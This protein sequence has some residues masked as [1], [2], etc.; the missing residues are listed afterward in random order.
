VRGKFEFW[1][2]EFIKTAPENP[3]LWAGMKGVSAEGRKKLSEMLKRV[4]HDNSVWFSFFVIPNLFRD[5]GFKNF[6]FK[7]PP[8]RRGSLVGIWDLDIWIFPPRRDLA[9][10]TPG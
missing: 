9:P 2:L 1:G 6:G 7:A 8:C 10:A 3:V 5:L 4:Q